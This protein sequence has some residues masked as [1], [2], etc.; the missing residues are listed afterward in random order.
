MPHLCRW[1]SLMMIVS[2][3]LLSSPDAIRGC[4]FIIHCRPFWTPTPIEPN[5]L[6]SWHLFKEKFANSVNSFWHPL[7]RLSFYVALCSHCLQGYIIPSWTNFR[8]EQDDPMKLPHSHIACKVTSSLHVLFLARA[9]KVT[10]LY[11]C[12]R[13]WV[14]SSVSKSVCAFIF[15]KTKNVHTDKLT[16]W[17]SQT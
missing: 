6:D 8:V 17:R 16:D 15:F 2:I 5:I 11:V 4:S 14:S 1:N 13:Q 7:K 3:S 9:T 10:S 12:V